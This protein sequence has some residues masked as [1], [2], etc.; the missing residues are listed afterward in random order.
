MIQMMKINKQRGANLIF[1]NPVIHSK[2]KK[3]IKIKFLNKKM[4]LIIN[5]KESKILLKIFPLKSKRIANK[6]RKMIE[7]YI[8]SIFII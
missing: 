1:F 8:F 4:I 5:F 7:I 6:T 3:S 2:K